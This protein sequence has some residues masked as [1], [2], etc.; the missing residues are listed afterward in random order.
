MLAFLGSFLGARAAENLRNNSAAILLLGGENGVAE[1]VG[2]A[3]C[4]YLS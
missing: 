4:A 2:V 1:D 3:V